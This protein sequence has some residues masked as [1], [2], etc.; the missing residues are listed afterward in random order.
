MKQ[1]ILCLLFWL[2]F[3]VFCL[4]G[5]CFVGLVVLLLFL[6]KGGVGE[7]EDEFW[8]EEESGKSRRRKKNMQNKLYKT[9]F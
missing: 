1:T 7:E 2:Q 6:E 4:F 5:F 9:F 8:W 3:G